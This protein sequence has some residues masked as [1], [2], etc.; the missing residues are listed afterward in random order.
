MIDHKTRFLALRIFSATQKSKCPSGYYS[1][2]SFEALGVPFQ[3]CRCMDLRAK[4]I[5]SLST[6]N[7]GKP[8]VLLKPYIVAMNMAEF[9]QHLKEL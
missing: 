7:D 9:Q 4:G 8:G 2:V 1:A 3:Y 6:A 5:L